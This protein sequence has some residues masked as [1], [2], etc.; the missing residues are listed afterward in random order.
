M[1]RRG[2]AL[3]G[4]VSQAQNCRNPIHRPTMQLRASVFASLIV[5]PIGGALPAQQVPDVVLLNAKLFTADST[6]PWAEAIAI[7]GERVQAVGSSA[8]MRALAGAGTRV[9]DVGGLTIV[10]GFNDAHDHIN[11]GWPGVFIDMNAGVTD[12]PAARVLD[13]IAAAV[14]R[15]PAGSWIQADIWT[16]AL[17]DTA[18]RRASLDR[19]APRNPVLV[20]M[21][22]GHGV[23]V[24]SLAM[25]AL[26]LR[27]S[28][29]DPFGG[30]YERDA[31]GRLTGKM[32]EYAGWTAVRK[33][34]SSLPDSVL[35]ANLRRYG[36]NELRYGI[37]SVQDMA[38][39]MDAMTT[40]RAFA[41]AN[42]PLRLHILRYSIPTSTSL[43]AAQ[44]DAVPATPAPRTIVSGR[45]WILDGTPIEQGAF[46]RR[47]Y[48]G[49]RD[50]HGRLNFPVDSIRSML[51]DALKTDEIMALHISGD[52][53]AV[54]V[55]SLMESLAPDSVW[56]QH[57][58]RFEHLGALTPDLWPRASAK[59][60]V[61][62]ANLQ[63][64][65]PPAVS[66]NLPPVPLAAM[67]PVG[68]QMGLGS[69][70]EPRSP[71]VGLYYAM[72]F[73]TEPKL[74]RE[75]LVR[76]YTIGSAYAEREEMNKGSL[77]AGKL[78]D[79]AVLSQDIFTVPVEALPN[80]ESV[81]TMIG[82]WI[83]Y[84]AGAIPGTMGK[85]N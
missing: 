61:N 12:P 7:R 6:A 33:L 19:V 53:T 3:P 42:L 64:L 24:N 80:T 44:W 48:P 56:R 17:S 18:L 67:D 4:P 70:G 37:T 40:G 52:S 25:R 5:F 73:P 21:P 47:P 72:S 69:D 15:V 8:G 75:R 68:L 27:D 36:Q 1:G 30:W 49:R 11:G 38:H 2:S 58:L 45:K 81:L 32:D 84:D 9:I 78:A 59:G 62:V 65:P 54:I 20:Q 55:L 26:G 85:P 60:I 31:R 76:L 74:S 34:R 77:T 79:L 83:E 57:R 23:I 10:P 50:Y 22:T 82:G 51:A 29:P 28:E 63:L 39:S 66:K 46:V 13:S 41:Q 71:F 16:T 14:K 43:G 35:V